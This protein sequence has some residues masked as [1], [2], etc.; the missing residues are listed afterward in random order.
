MKQDVPRAAEAGPD[1]AT[2]PRHAPLLA[3]RRKPAGSRGARID[4]M[5]RGWT[6]ALERALGAAVRAPV[7]IGV[8]P[9]VTQPLAD[10]LTETERT[11]RAVAVVDVHPAGARPATLCLVP[12]RT[13]LSAL[14]ERFY[15]GGAAGKGA[16]HHAAA[17]RPLSNAEAMMLERL[18]FAAA[19]AIVHDGSP[20]GARVVEPDDVDDMVD[21]IGAATSTHGLALS[22]AIEG[23][24]NL[25]TLRILVPAALTGASPG[26]QDP[27]RAARWRVALAARLADVHVPAKGV[28]ARPTLTLREV[29]RLRRGDV[30]PIGVPTSVPLIVGQRRVALGSIGERDGRAAFLVET[31]VENP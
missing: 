27:E 15:G 2:E 1:A 14:I 24:A 18:A 29:G 19:A 13:L 20:S 21:A 17:D 16:R 6:P 7:R 25:G 4:A 12:D 22:V 5:V 11:G 3:T 30:I 8:P 26:T 23:S 28:L 10:W 31:L 9:A